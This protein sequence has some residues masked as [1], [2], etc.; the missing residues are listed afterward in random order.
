MK[1]A[2]ECVLLWG[3]AGIIILP[4]WFLYHFTIFTILEDTS[5]SQPE[6]TPPPEMCHTESLQPTL[7]TFLHCHT[8]L[9]QSNI[10][11]FQLVSSAGPFLAV[12]ADYYTSLR[13]ISGV[14]ADHN[15]INLE[16]NSRRNRFLGEIQ[17]LM[18]STL[19]N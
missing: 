12:V 9:K 1:L 3:Q 6:T 15:E 16:V 18:T 7:Y 13:L 19:N 2:L 10:Q 4:L 17:H 11:G 5:H 8:H 14:F